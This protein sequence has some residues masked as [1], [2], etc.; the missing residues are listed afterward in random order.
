M[1]TREPATISEYVIRSAEREVARY[2]ADG[3]VIATPHGSSGYA[4]SSGG[5]IVASDIAALSVVPISAYRTADDHWV[6]PSVS[7]TVARDET[8]VD[9][10]ADEQ[11]VGEVAFEETLDV[12]PGRSFETIRLPQSRSPYDNGA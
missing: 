4:R 5:A 1:L 7:L 12:R 6:L 2:R 10:F 8:P 11:S 3:I 9:V